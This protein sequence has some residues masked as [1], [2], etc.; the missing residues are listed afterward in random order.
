MNG[1][2]ISG[3]LL[4]EKSPTS[5]ENLFNGG[6]NLAADNTKVGSPLNTND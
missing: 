2:E 5:S 1:S 3:L 6:M 4:R